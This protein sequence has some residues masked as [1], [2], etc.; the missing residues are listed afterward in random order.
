MDWFGSNTFDGDDFDGS[1]SDDTISYEGFSEFWAS[2]IITIDLEF[3]NSYVESYEN[4]FFPAIEP[5]ER[6]EFSRNTFSSIENAIGSNFDD[7][8]IGSSGKNIINSL[9][10]NDLISGGFGDDIIYGGSGN[11][12]LN[13]NYFGL[14]GR[15]I[16][17]LESNTSIAFDELGNKRDTDKIY[18]IENV[19]GSVGNDE[20][21]GNNLNNTLDGGLGSNKLYGLGGD[22][23]LI[24][25]LGGDYLDGGDGSDTVDY[26]FATQGL[27]GGLEV[28][29]IQNINGGTGAD[30]LNSIE[31]IIASDFDDHLY[32]NDQ[33]N[34]I[35]GRN[36]NDLLFGLG[37][38]DTLIGDNGN[39]QIYGGAGDDQLIGGDGNDQILGDS[40]DDQLIGGKGDDQLFGGI[41]N[42]RLIDGEG[43]N[44]FY[45]GDGIDYADFST[46]TTTGIDASLSTGIAKNIFSSSIALTPNLIGIENLQG[47]RFNDVFEGDY[48]SNVINGGLGADTVSYNYLSNGD[49]I[50][51][52]LSTGQ[53]F[54]RD[55]TSQL[56]NTG[57]LISIDTDTLIS[58]ENLTGGSGNDT[59]NGND[60]DN[61]LIGGAGADSLSGG[62]GNDVIYAELGQDELIDGGDGVDTLHVIFTSGN[63]GTDRKDIKF[64][65]TSGFNNFENFVGSAFSETIWGDSQNNRIDGGLGNDRI[66]G[67]T[68]DDILVGGDG[69]NSISGGFGHNIIDGTNSNNSNNLT[70]ITTA[71]YSSIN[72]TR[73]LLLGISSLKSGPISLVINLKLE[74]G[75]VTLA[76][77]EVSTLELTDD[78]LNISSVRAGTGNDTMI[79]NDQ[80]NF[81]WGYDGDDVIFGDGGD[82]IIVGGKG[83]DSL[84][85]GDGADIFGYERPFSSGIARTEVDTIADFGFGGNDKIDL[86]AFVGLTTNT[87]QIVNGG[88]ETNIFIRENNFTQKIIL[89]N[90]IDNEITLADF[91]LVGF[92]YPQTNLFDGYVNASSLFG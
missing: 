20:I 11:D 57:L 60:Q 86:R 22:D 80:D 54:V 82:D 84:R 71:D 3:Q 56:I 47:S 85:G 36:G 75:N 48:G 29:A 62:G 58:I 73:D 18:E 63:I 2:P 41:G 30:F 74:K 89:E 78:F 53:V 76:P 9:G 70:N 31:N 4:I 39:D 15:A 72:L 32:G 42:D 37:G 44:I 43:S 28:Q 19:I 52:N 81:F 26:R 51:A 14:Y 66:L 13:M 50:S 65:G 69:L 24:S 92:S 64:D 61:A 16:V 21:S 87:L 1:Q 34:R 7:L 88:D 49:W 91:L 17:S 27:F 67:G 33:R 59:L 10:G 68:G 46:A 90:P 45:G 25:R 5:S 83:N 55:V 35:E 77:S 38:N 40:G 23:T 8:I 79:G 12:T 6:T